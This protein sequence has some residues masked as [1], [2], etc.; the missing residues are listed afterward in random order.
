MWRLIPYVVRFRA[1]MSRTQRHA[2]VS[3]GR[4][5]LAFEEG[6]HTLRKDVLRCLAGH[7]SCRTHKAG[8]IIPGSRRVGALRRRVRRRA[9]T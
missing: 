1:A 6:A 8:Q 9:A 2:L 4:T 5:I 3:A 7:R